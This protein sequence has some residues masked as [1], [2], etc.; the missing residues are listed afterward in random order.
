MRL[1]TLSTSTFLL[2]CAFILP[3]LCTPDI[4]IKRDWLLEGYDGIVSFSGVL[5]FD[6]KPD[7]T[8]PVQD[9]SDAQLVGVCA[10][11][12]DEM[13]SADGGNDKPGAMALLAIENEV[14]LA[15]SIK[16][17][18]RGWLGEGRGTDEQRPQILAKAAGA[19]RIAGSFHRIGGACA[20]VNIMDVYYQRKQELD[21]S[22]KKARLV[23]WATK[24][25]DTNIFNPCST[26]ANGYGCK[27]FLQAV[28]NPSNPREPLKAENLKVIAKSTNRDDSWPDGVNFS[29][30]SVRPSTDDK[31]ALCMDIDE[32]PF[33][34][35][36]PDQ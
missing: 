32:D 5:V 9:L 1:W 16:G 12:F 22:G 23:V 36:N 27:D 7:K 21:F 29:F 8:N 31:A 4:G 20:E 18:R 11:A 6:A 30:N 2:L 28:G 34:P 35:N 13:R 24:D 3:A 17:D 10:K 33:D 25:G 14:Y 26:P 19:A 15:S